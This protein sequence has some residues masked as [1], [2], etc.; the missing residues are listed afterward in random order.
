MKLLSTIGKSFVVFASMFSL[1]YLSLCIIF[2]LIFGY[3]YT[4]ESIRLLVGL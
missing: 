4:K 3:E 1:L 2:V